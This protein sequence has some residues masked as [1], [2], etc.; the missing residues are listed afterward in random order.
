[1][2]APLLLTVP[3]AARSLGLGRSTLFA[4]IAAGTIPAVKV[5]GAR[6]VRAS[7]LAAFVA[8]LSA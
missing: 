1:M 5:G 3:E 2:T 4:M 6:R 8:D 7:D